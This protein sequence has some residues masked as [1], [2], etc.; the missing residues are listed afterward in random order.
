M[1]RLFH[2]LNYIESFDNSIQGWESFES[3]RIKRGNETF[4]N[5]L[6]DEH[7][8]SLHVDGS[9]VTNSI[10]FNSGIS[11]TF[12]NPLDVKWSEIHL[13]YRI[14][15]KKGRARLNKLGLAIFK[16]SIN[17]RLSHNE[18]LFQ[19]SKITK[20]QRVNNAVGNDSG[21]QSIIIDISHIRYPIISV[22]FYV[23][24]LE[25]YDL[26]MEFWLDNIAVLREPVTG[27]SGYS[28]ADGHPR[29]G[30]PHTHVE[31]Y[32]KIMGVNKVNVT[33]NRNRG[34]NSS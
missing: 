22:L 18:F 30:V 31:T 11:K 16:N 20:H 28:L 6:S 33:T 19:G 32:K 23:S 8:G 10:R 29:K 21:W 17:G 25:F 3:S 12:I 34:R 15:V 1:T 5:V 26:E 2:S 9:H 14:K 4:N 13:D 7:G 27:E 24:N